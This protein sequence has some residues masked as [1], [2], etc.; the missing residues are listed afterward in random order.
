MPSQNTI[1]IYPPD[2]IARIARSAALAAEVLEHAVRMV[3]PG[4]NTAEIDEFCAGYIASRGAIAAPLNYR[5]FPKSICTSP[6]DV[7]CHGIPSPDMVLQEG[8]IV[9]IDITVLLDGYYGDTS[10]TVLVGEVPNGVKLFVERAEK[11]MWKG[12][13]A[14]VVGHRFNA[15]GDAIERYVKKFDY[16]VVRDYCGHGIGAA[17]HEDPAV[18]HYSSRSALPMLQNGMVFTVE[19]MINMG[20]NWRSEVDQIDGW[21]ARTVDGSLSAQFE[22][23]VAIVNGKAHVLSVPPHSI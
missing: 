5:G 6:N 7:I 19:P 23:T 18:L 14:A 9:N 10:R 4:V 11:A 21:T 15:I 13:E 1:K 22:H 3:Q 20:K 12:I 17:F 2:T 8:D 16:S